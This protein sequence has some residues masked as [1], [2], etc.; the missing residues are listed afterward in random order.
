[1]C[2]NLRWRENGA[3]T[4]TLLPLNSWTHR[5]CAIASETAGW[6]I[7][8]THLVATATTSCCHSQSSFKC[9]RR[10]EGEGGVTPR[11]HRGSH[12][13]P[14][15]ALVQPSTGPAVHP[16]L[17]LP[18]HPLLAKPP[19]RWSLSI[20]LGRDGQHGPSV[21]TD[22]LGWLSF[23][24]LCLFHLEAQEWFLWCTWVRG[25]EWLC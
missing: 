8:Y 10:P 3:Y 18:L 21:L 22:L 6:S 11:R 23:P 17:P 15:G 5:T 20:A 24:W 19:L 14:S 25:G 16:P 2:K 13:R 9:N 1:M 4:D 12:R 7:H